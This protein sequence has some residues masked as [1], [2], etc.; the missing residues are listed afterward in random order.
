MEIT[1]DNILEGRLQVPARFPGFDEEAEFGDLN[2]PGGSGDAGDYPATGSGS[3][4]DSGYEI[5]RNSNIFG[6]QSELL[7]DDR[8]GKPFVVISLVHL[9]FLLVWKT[10]R[11]E[12]GFRRAQLNVKRSYSVARRCCLQSPGNGKFI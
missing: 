12:I 7:R 4:S 5:E 10:F 9:S 11:W 2:Q 8:Y 3:S 1:I 6:N